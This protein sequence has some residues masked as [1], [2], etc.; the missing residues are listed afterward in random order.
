MPRCLADAHATRAKSGDAGKGLC[1]HGSILICV[2]EQCLHNAAH[3]KASVCAEHGTA[4]HAAGVRRTTAKLTGTRR[5][6][7]QIDV[8]VEGD[9]RYI[10]AMKDGGL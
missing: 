6:R 7:S 5:C 3:R 4:S 1:A 8:I 10:I 2:L 9:S